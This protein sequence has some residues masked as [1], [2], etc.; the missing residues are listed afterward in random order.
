M[1]C[2]PIYSGL[3]MNEEISPQKAHKAQKK[4]TILPF[5]PCALFVVKFLHMWPGHSKAK[6]CR[7]KQKKQ[8]SQKRQKFWPF[9]ILLLFLPFL[10]L[11]LLSL[12]GLV[13]EICPV[14]RFV[15]YFLFDLDER[16]NS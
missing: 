15:P 7:R 11:T 1:S 14:I 4:P 12:R 5:A 13:L 8:K 2:G 6:R 9:C 10:F 3:Q 16:G